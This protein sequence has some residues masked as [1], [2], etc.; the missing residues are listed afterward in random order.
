MIVMPLQAFGLGDVIFSMRLVE[1][2]SFEYGKCEIIWPVQKHFVEGLNRAYPYVK[3]IDESVISKHIFDIK[4]DTILDGHIR[5]LPIR[6]SDSIMKVPYK[7]VM[8]AKYDMYKM[9]WR[10]WRNA[11]YQRSNEREQRLFKD[12]LGL[13]QG[14]GYCLVNQNF[15]SNASRK[16]Q[17]QPKTKMPIVNVKPIEGYSL[18]D[19]SY[20]IEQAAEIHTVGTS[21][22]YII[23]LL[24]IKASH[25]TLYKRLPLENHYENYNYILEKH[26]YIFTL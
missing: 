23:E 16:S 2:I 9:D 26:K 19:W 7:Y 22:N 11:M 18:F 17:I 3:F 6:W 8:K 24:N 4:Q 14:M 21:I 13:K 15:T 5:I 1:E 20:V 12:V 10:L 25:V